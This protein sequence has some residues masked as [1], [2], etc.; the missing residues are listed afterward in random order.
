MKAL[1]NR[2]KEKKSKEDADG[3]LES[4]GKKFSSNGSIASQ[5]NGVNKT[6]KGKHVD[7][8]ILHQDDTWSFS[9]ITKHLNK[10]IALSEPVA[11][12]DAIDTTTTTVA[13]ASISLEVAGDI[14]SSHHP[15][16]CETSPL[17]T[18]NPAHTFTKIDTHTHYHQYHNN[19]NC[20]QKRNIK[21][22]IYSYMLS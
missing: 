18:N 19:P 11:D 1:H 20:K 15:H 6:G 8:L 22:C 16:S 10:E 5:A 4:S 17:I 13:Y 7:I 21:K 2:R 12:N 3:N 14:K 9:N